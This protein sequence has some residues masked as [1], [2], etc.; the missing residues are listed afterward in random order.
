LN[1]FIFTLLFVLSV[2]VNAF[3]MKREAYIDVPTANLNQG[4][5][6]NV[7]SSYPIKDV[8]D[9]KF[10][11]NV[12]IDLSYR[13]FGV[14]MKWYD[15]AD[16]ALD[17]SYQIL[18]DNGV[19][20][21][22][23]IGINELS[24]SEYV[25]PAGN[26]DVFNDENY[27]DRSP[28]ISSVYIVGTKKISRNF[29]VTAGTGR[30]KFVGY[31]PMSKYANTDVFFDENHEDWAVGIFGGIKIIFTNNLA[32]IAEGDGRD[33]NLGLEY[34]NKL[35]KGTL[36]LSKL[37]VFNDE[38]YDL[39]PRVGLNL[40]YK[41][42]NLKE[43]DRK[44]VRK[45]RKKFP[46]VIELVDGISRELV[47]GYVIITGAKGDTIEVSGFKDVHSFKIEPGVYTMLISAT[48]YKDRKIG[49]VVK[50][51]I[52]KNLHTIEMSKIE[53]S[54]RPLEVE[55][56]VKI[57]DN[58]E[59][60]KD[61]VEGISIRF[62]FREAELT[63]RA[64]NILNRIIELIR[65]NKNVRLLVTG[66]T[67]SRGTLESNRELS[68]KRAENVKKYLIEHGIPAGSISTKGYGETKPI[69]GNG[70][71]EGRIKN[72]R[73]EFILYRVNE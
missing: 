61:Q 34:Q 16:F 18:Q 20:P 72:R 46:V 31:G 23:A 43:E 36:A 25:S 1:R 60:V 35:I 5:Y 71:E 73:V 41:V 50:E 44:E 63:T 9:V 38:E 10:D 28:E 66:H 54:G 47:E 30:G 14:A 49:I 39:S 8:D 53:E 62:F 64:R 56:S 4:L 7:N 65:N 42:M 11:P 69:A 15:G 17:V 12:G 40:S 22:F 52:S 33:I 26:E 13:K 37:E 67:C 57:I 48:G 24:T 27:T 32:F 29:E 2:A 59:E 51:E 68:E 58:F 70:T 19:F 21:S 3:Q 45:E 6:I 55:D